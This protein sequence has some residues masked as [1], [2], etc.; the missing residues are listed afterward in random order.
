[1][2]R[3]VVST[4]VY[5]P[6]EDAYEF[7][8]DFPG[9]EQYTEYLDRVARTE[10][11]GGPGSRYA[12]KFSWWKLSYTARSQVTEVA[13]PTRI[14]W[15]ITEDIDAEGCWRIEPYEDLPDDA[16]PD[17]TDASEVRM[18]IEFDPD[19]ADSDAVSLPFGVSF[20]WVLDRVKGLVEEEATRVVRRAVADLEG[21]ARDVTLDVTTDS[22][23]L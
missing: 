11:D 22:D 1:V 7:L 5:V 23:A 19:S 9:Y 18:V 4:D 2:D 16:P 6:P 17:A 14:D 21:D 20:G 10:G 12:L 15:A 8:L 13:P 3:L